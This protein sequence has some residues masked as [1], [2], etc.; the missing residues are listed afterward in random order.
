MT[1]YDHRIMPRHDHG[2]YGTRSPVL[3]P[4]PAGTPGGGIAAWIA[5]PWSP[6]ATSHSAAAADTPVPQSRSRSGS[7]TGLPSGGAL[8]ATPRTRVNSLFAA[9][10]FRSRATNNTSPTDVS[11]LDDDESSRHRRPSE[12]VVDAAR[13]P[14]RTPPCARRA[15]R[16]GHGRVSIGVTGD[17]AVAVDAPQQLPRYCTARATP[18]AMCTPV[19]QPVVMAPNTP[20][21][22]ATAVSS[23]PIHVAAVAAEPIP[24]MRPV[25]APNALRADGGAFAPGARPL[26]PPALVPPPRH[27][28]VAIPRVVEHYG[29]PERQRV[30]A[31]VAARLAVASGFR[32]IVAPACAL[33]AQH[34]PARRSGEGLCGTPAARERFYLCSLVLSGC[35]AI[36]MWTVLG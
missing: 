6:F 16:H 32:A 8:E 1:S 21:C 20:Y 2:I 12:G 3:A 10:P 11:A 23:D 13:T 36:A 17:V 9:S 30:S 28:I 35:C 15:A 26:P 34:R 22:E 29:A 14:V 27:H 5:G 7:V 18:A 4:C 33:P 31:A 25:V 24:A 19:A